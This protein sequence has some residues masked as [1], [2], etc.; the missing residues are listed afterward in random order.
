MSLNFEIISKDCLSSAA[1]QFIQKG[2]VRF[3]ENTK[4]NK[5]AWVTKY[6][7]AL[8]PSVELPEKL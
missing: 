7:L 6:V 8:K 1:C 2:H 4:V 3:R 5:Q